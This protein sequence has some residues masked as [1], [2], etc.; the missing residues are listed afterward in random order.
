MSAHTPEEAHAL[1]VAA[2]NAGDPDAF[3][4]VYEQDAA[5][6]VPPDEVLVNGREEIRKAI[7]PTFA[8]APKAEIEVLKKVQSDGLALTQ[9]RWRLVGTDPEGQTVT[10]T[11]DGAIVSRRQPDGSWLIV[12]DNPV[13]PR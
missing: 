10:L 9:A 7:E 12:L 1:L 6:I 8:L 5:L 3:V 13:R 11:G 2:F 4:Q